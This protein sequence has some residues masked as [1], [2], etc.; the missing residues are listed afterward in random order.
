MAYGDCVSWV[1]PV[2]Y[3][4]NGGVNYYINDIRYKTK[5]G[6]SGDITGQSN[7]VGVSALTTN[8]KDFGKG[9]CLVG[10]STE[11]YP[12]TSYLSRIKFHYTTGF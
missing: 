8:I 7:L 6:L 11:T 5:N 12:G 1:Q 9:N 4:P 10:F 3:T 2:T